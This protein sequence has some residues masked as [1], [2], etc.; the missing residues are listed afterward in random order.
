MNANDM[1]DTC[2]LND[3]IRNKSKLFFY[4]IVA[5]GCVIRLKNA[6][7]FKEAFMRILNIIE[8]GAF[9]IKVILTAKRF[10]DGGSGCWCDLKRTKPKT[11]SWSK[12]MISHMG[13]E[14]RPQLF[15]GCSVESWAMGETLTQQ[16]RV[17]ENGC[18]FF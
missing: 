2:K 11:L 15:K 9:Y 4:K 7:W 17:S 13:T 1:L 18:I 8:A 3:F 6:F 12:W 14:T 10:L 5:H 16:C